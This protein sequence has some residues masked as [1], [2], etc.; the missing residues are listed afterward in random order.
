MRDLYGRIRKDRKHN[1]TAV[2][3]ELTGGS[4]PNHPLGQRLKQTEQK[5]HSQTE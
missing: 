5:D 3:S 1:V 2:A 4:S